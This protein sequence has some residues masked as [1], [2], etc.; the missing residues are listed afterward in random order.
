MVRFLLENS[1]GAWWAARHPDSP[2]VAGFEYLR[3]DDDGSP[4]AGSFD[5][6]PE[7]VAEVTVMDPCCGSGHFLVEAFGM[8]WRMRPRRKA[9]SPGRGQ[10]AVLARQPVR[11]RARPPLRA[12]RDVRR[13]FTGVEGRRW[14]ASVARCRTSRVR[15][16]PSKRQ[17]TNGKSSPAATSDLK[18]RSIRL[19]ILFRDAD[20]LGSLIDPKRST[21]A[22]TR[23]EQRS[24][25]DVD[26]GHDCTADRAGGES[27]RLEIPPTLVLGAAATGRAKAA[28][29]LSR[30]YMLIA[31]NV[32]YLHRGQAE[33]DASCGRRSRLSGCIYRPCN[34]D[35]WSVLCALWIPPG[36][37]PLSPRRTG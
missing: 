34:D 16:S 31:T 23:L 30:K 19:H 18:T 1:L 4:A 14:L 12:D 25:E 9:L 26:W 35:A 21:E 22:P 37:W 24:I 33:R 15:A 28:D 32:P 5:G 27:R 29:L 10:D 11:A 17:S 2:L 7:R 36:F 6:W 8:L 3:F 20:T 13:R